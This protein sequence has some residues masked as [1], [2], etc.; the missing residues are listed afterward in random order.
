MTTG[1][2]HDNEVVTSAALVGRL[3][4]SQFPQWAHLPIAPVASAGTDN[5]LY[6]LGEAMVV[7]LP[8]VDWAIDQV[9]KEQ[10]WLPRLAPHLPL[11]IPT[12]LAQ[13]EP[14]EGYPWSWSIYQW[15]AGEVVTIE[16]L[17]DP[18][19]AALD[20]AQFILALQQ[21]DTTNAPLY[22]AHNSFRG[23]PLALRDAETRAA[24]STLRGL[25]DSELATAVWE[26]AV[27]APAWSGPPVWLHGDLRPGN[28]LAH[29]GRLSA[30]IDFGLLGTGDP[31]TDVMAA[32]LFLSAE[33]RHL[34]RTALQVDEATWAR[35]RGWALNFGAMALP[36]YQQSN[37]DL[38]AIAHR[39][40]QETLTDYL[41]S[42]G[43]EGLTP[44][45]IG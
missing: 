5:A 33:T 16:Q 37:P 14:G 21:I 3:L 30:V 45:G 28:L 15:L 18:T 25:I 2:M 22:G 34:F 43:I 44:P 6:R 11:T 23:E 42:T 39:V 17:S 26:S 1:K 24:I 41:G 20:L 10:Q 12:P 4:A 36:Y 8:R 29:A 13:G 31:A 9:A 40:I 32:W 7:R 35:G 27:A 38:A 19:Q